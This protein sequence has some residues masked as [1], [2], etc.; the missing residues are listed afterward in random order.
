[1]KRTRIKQRSGSECQRLER[2]C[3]ALWQR[4]IVALWRGRCAVCGYIGE[5]VVGHHIVGRRVKSLRHKLLNG[6]AVC[7]TCHAR[8]HDNPV[9][10]AGWLDLHYPDLAWWARQY[11]RG[12][13]TVRWAHELRETRKALRETL[14]RLEAGNDTGRI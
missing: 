9:A 14:Q 7:G 12:E 1:M 6:I 4:C 5:G 11:G 10:F 13:T 3:D 8:A 2:E